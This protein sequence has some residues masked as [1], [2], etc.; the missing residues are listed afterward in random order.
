M[1]AS[2]AQSYP[3]THSVKGKEV[4]DVKFFDSASMPYVVSHTYLVTASRHLIP[5][6]T[7]W[8]ACKDNQQTFEDEGKGGIF[9]RVRFLHS[10]SAVCWFHISRQAFV[11]ALGTYHVVHCEWGSYCS[12]S[13]KKPRQRHSE[14][15]RSVTCVPSISFIVVPLP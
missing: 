9:G 6:Q 15:L 5:Q 4:E 11:R 3:I 10:G 7:S 13:A 14:L 1:R 12:T 2:S 8:S